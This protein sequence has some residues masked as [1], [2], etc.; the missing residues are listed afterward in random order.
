MDIIEILTKEWSISMYLATGIGIL[1]LV[2]LGQN[3]RLK[4]KLKGIVNDVKAYEDWSHNLYD[5]VVKRLR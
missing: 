4:R 1:I 2:L 3:F 5:W